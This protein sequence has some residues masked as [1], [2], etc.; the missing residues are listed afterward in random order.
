MQLEQILQEIKE[1]E[2]RLTWEGTFAEY[3]QKVVED[4]GLARLAHARIHDAIHHAGVSQGRLGHTQYDLFAGQLFGIEDT[5]A[6]I[7]EYFDSAARRLETRKRILLLVGPPASGK[8]TIVNLLKRGLENYTRAGSGATY[9]IKGCPM[10]EEPLHL[11][12]PEFRGELENKYG[13]HIEGHLCPHCR[14]TLKEQYNGEIDQV[15]VQRVTLSESMG[16][17][18]GTFVAGDPSSQ[19]L[20]RLTGSLDESAT[21]SDRMETF[22][23]AYRLNGEL[24]VANRGLMEFV[25]IFKLDER[26]LAV[27]LE[28]TEDQKIKAP[29]YGTIY[30]DEAVLAHTNM[31]EYESLVQNQ[32]TAGLQDRLVVV[33][34]PYNLR[35][36]D[37]QRIYE[38][39]L[40]NVDLKGTH[41]SPLCLPVASIF[42]VLSRLEP[43]QKFGMSMAQKLRLYDGQYVDRYTQEDAADL[44]AQAAGEGFMGVSPRFVI[45]QISRAVSREQVECLDPLD[46]LK[47]L[48]DGLRQS[49]SLA[50]A[51]N[52]R[53]EQLFMETRQQYDE[54]AKREVQKALVD[55]YDAT[56]TQMVRRY[57]Q[58]VKDY[59]Q[60]PEDY[61]HRMGH[62][63]GNLGGFMQSLERLVDVQDYNEDDFRR[64]I[65]AIAARL[66][67]AGLPLDDRLDPRL[68]EAIRRKLCPGFR[69]MTQVLA[70]RDG[71]DPEIRDQQKAIYH[72]LVA[73]RGFETHCARRLVEHVTG[74]LTQGTHTRTPFSKALDWIHT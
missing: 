1:K 66:E 45:N 55:D 18:I 23:K 72:R 35:V 9:A 54:M 2:S 73:E 37:E 25:E 33:R 52:D 71:G 53:L 51:E 62:T 64:D 70:P 19:V 27:L 44:H 69:E 58:G 57:V 38:K 39:L 15:K 34:V 5:I 59:V 41:M 3:F 16:I 32:K 21:G 7:V 56:A 6:Q 43:P 20:S 10:Q 4:P 42:A 47:T 40:A 24:N 68:E 31:A 29:G 49:T 14:W 48:W 63:N 22:G 36:S 74:L 8:S 30:A 11:I 46:L 65:A 13:L 12:P 60:N 50:R 67:A 28:L 26:F 61:T 17:G